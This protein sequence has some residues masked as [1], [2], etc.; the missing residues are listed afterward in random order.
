MTLLDQLLD[1]IREAHG[2]E[3][4][5]LQDL[6]NYSTVDSFGGAGVP[7][8]Y[9]TQNYEETYETVSYVY[10]AV[11]AITDAIIQL[12]IEVQKQVKDDWVNVTTNEYA[13]LAHYNDFMTSEQFWERTIISLELTGE[14]FWLIKRNAMGMITDLF[15]VP[16]AY[17]VVH[18]KNDFQVDYYTF[19]SPH[20]TTVDLR[21]ED[22]FF[23]KFPSP[24]NGVRGLSPLSA[25]K[26]DIVLDQSAVVSSQR[27]F[28]QGFR[29]S[30][31]FSTEQ[32]M[33]KAVWE[34]LLSYLQKEYAGS[35]NTGKALMLT[36]GL[37]WEQL[38][39]SNEELQYLGQ[40]QWSKSVVGQV[41]GVTPVMMM[42][43]KE[44]SVL[45]NADVQVKLFWENTIKPLTVRLESIFTTFLLPQI[46]KK[47]GLRFKWDFSKISV[48][49]PD[50]NKLVER[51][52]RG[53]KT[54]G[55]T[56]NQMSEALGLEKSLDPLMDMHYIPANMVP[57]EKAGQ[58]LNP[59]TED[60]PDKEDEDEK[61][62][63]EVEEDKYI[64]SLVMKGNKCMGIDIDENSMDF[65]MQKFNLRIK[66][67][68]AFAIINTN[69][70][71]VAH[72]FQP[73]LLKMLNQQRDEVL[74]N[75]NADKGMTLQGYCK[76]VGLKF[77][78]VHEKYTVEGV[79]FSYEE[80]A[81]KYEAAG[82]PF[83]AQAFRLAGQD[84][85][86]SI[87]ETFDAVNPASV[88][89]VNSR[90]YDYAQM[91]NN[92]TRDDINR[93]V[94]KGLEENLTTAELA[95]SLE[96]YFKNNNE[97]RAIRIARTETVVATNA[98][99]VGAMKQSG[100]IKDHM[101]L[102][103]RDSDVRDIAGDDHTRLDGNVVKVGASFAGNGGSDSGWPSSPN[104]RC[105]TIPFKVLPKKKKN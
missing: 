59:T 70:I 73:I 47:K 77:K 44:A 65:T 55:V 88:D 50:K 104:E 97:V 32:N 84:L 82:Q 90:S 10:R 25:A 93:I 89:W 36:D 5:N 87:D 39:L 14:S 29:P 103:Q 34:R 28:Q 69:E 37:K 96:G 3:T 63:E 48:I 1:P 67:A 64:T 33:S 76:S 21:E 78:K 62:P 8:N 17:M 7:A 58:T 4:K 75:L 66:R 42:D 79:N 43:F 35:I 99:R 95:K 57:L 49:Q 51:M 68:E 38:S 16:S 74:A 98:G 80:W 71:K 102:S 9:D 19:N 101:W 22:V 20:G 72:K 100:R 24:T 86:K 2:I 56:P 45:A 83:I 6:K 60:D 61:T 53:F 31:V 46:S 18:P 27:Q 85:A 41:F 54:A 12:P 30:G 26:A 52:E 91:V 105:L 92:T 15:P 11:S 40:R 94:A 81:E 13:V 23:I